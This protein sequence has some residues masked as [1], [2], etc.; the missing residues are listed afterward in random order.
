M[1]VK[2][3]P[4]NNSANDAIPSMTPTIFM[5]NRTNPATTNINPRICVA[6]ISMFITQVIE[7][8]KNKNFTVI[9]TMGSN[10]AKVPFR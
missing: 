2:Y 5:N 8:A 9:L 7:H 6:V 4:I 10:G 1:P 3:S